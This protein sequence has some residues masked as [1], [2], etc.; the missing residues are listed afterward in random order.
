VR[1]LVLLAVLA[2]VGML[3]AC[4]GKLPPAG[5][6]LLKQINTSYR[7][8]DY[9]GTVQKADEFLAAYGDTEAAGEAYYLRGLAYVSLRDHVRAWSDL[10]RAVAAAH[11]SD[12]VPLAQVAMGNLAFE[13]GRLAQAAQHYQPVVADL[14]NDSPKDIVLFRLG[15]CYTRLGQWKSGRTWFSELIA[16]FPASS[17]EPRARRY[18]A[19]DGF[20]VQCGA[21]LDL[22]RAQR[23]VKDVGD[24]GLDARW[25]Q[26]PRMRYFLVQVGSFA[27]YQ[28][29]RA[30]LANVLRVVPDALIVPY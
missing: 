26:D 15:V 2:V 25:V 19:A 5:V 11:R 20:T 27:T 17:L 6:T 21:Y 1:R 13:E 9:R 30:E 14:P 22:A 24:R 8:N 29:A 28:E 12:L 16:R 4:V 10:E 3:S 23:Q 7:Q 18:I